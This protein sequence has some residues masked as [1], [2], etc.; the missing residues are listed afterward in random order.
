MNFAQLMTLPVVYSS[1]EWY[2]AC[3]IVKDICNQHR[4]FDHFSAMMDQLAQLDSADFEV[5]AAK[6]IRRNDHVSLG[7]DKWGI[8]A[9]V[10]H[11]DNQP[12]IGFTQSGRY[13]EE[14]TS[15]L[16]DENLWNNF[17]V[18]VKECIEKYC[19]KSTEP[20]DNLNV[21]RPENT[22][23][24]DRIGNYCLDD[25]YDLSGV[26]EYAEGDLVWAWVAENHLMYD[27]K[28]VLVK[29]EI[30]TVNSKRKYEQYHGW[31]QD[32]SYCPDHPSRYFIKKGESMGATPVFILGKV[33]DIPEPEENAYNLIDENTSYTLTLEEL[34]TWAFNYDL[35]KHNIAPV[36]CNLFE[37][38]QEFDIPQVIWEDIDKVYC[39]EDW[40][41]YEEHSGLV[42]YSR[43]SAPNYLFLHNYGYS[44]EI[45]A[46]GSDFETDEK[47]ANIKYVADEINSWKDQD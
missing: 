18:F 25:E 42:V 45:G 14:Y 35:K 21:A 43:K 41:G 19:E 11:F 36:E 44:V 12:F 38:Q 23:L 17:F 9:G 24:P 8:T 22:V 20:E 15:Y 6:R 13:Q 3:R 2:G 37:L 5:E 31:Q 28:Y 32:R 47:T 4:R 7:D 10:L 27:T 34:S 26:A 30:R 40:S 39:V 46:Y 29:V 33:S 1:D 16:F